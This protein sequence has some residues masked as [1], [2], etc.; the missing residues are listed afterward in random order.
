MKFLAIACAV[1]LAACA[2][3]AEP[4]VGAVQ[5]AATPQVTSQCL[6]QPT[7]PGCRE[8]CALH[9]SEVWCWAR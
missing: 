8:T 6:R 5:P 7:F 4:R 9:P 2:G 1:A 3:K